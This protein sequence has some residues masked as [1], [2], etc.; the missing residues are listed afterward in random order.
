M[1]I[2]NVSN[3][4]G[5]FKNGDI[6][7][8]GKNN[9][10]IKNIGITITGT[11]SLSNDNG[12]FGQS[13]FGKNS[14][15]HKIE[16]CYSDGEIGGDNCGGIL[17]SYSGISGA[18]EVTNSYS[19]GTISGANS[20]GIVGPNGGTCTINNCF[21]V[22]EVTGTSAVILSNDGTITNSY[23]AEGDWNDDTANQ[24]LQNIVCLLYTSDAADE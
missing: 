2:N 12:W 4:N 18:I 20:A 15:G 23:G 21:S 8:D 22:G 10:T 3:F 17:G 1:T 14:T 11:T 16:K 5:L 13:Y 24:Y 6:S 7:T 19:K 9:V